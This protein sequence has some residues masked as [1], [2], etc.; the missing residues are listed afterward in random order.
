MSR[1]IGSIKDVYLQ[2]KY[3]DFCSNIFLS[4]QTKLC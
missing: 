2:I 4:D 3:R 1:S